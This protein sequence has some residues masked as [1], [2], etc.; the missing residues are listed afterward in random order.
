MPTRMTNSTATPAYLD[1]TH[2]LRQLHA[3]IRNGQGESDQ[4]DA[5]R[6][7]M[8]EAWERLDASEIHRAR[9]LSADLNTLNLE[10]QPATDEIQESSSQSRAD[11]FILLMHAQKHGDWSK[12]LTDH[13]EDLNPDFAT[14]LRALTWLDRGDRESALLFLSFVGRGELAGSEQPPGDSIF[15]RRAQMAE[16]LMELGQDREAKFFLKTFLPEERTFCLKSR[17]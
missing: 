3:L 2:L 6:E 1:Y 7:A 9:Q 15:K 13:A 16:E 11:L 10:S 8:D 5:L 4:A 12:L 14:I 17:L